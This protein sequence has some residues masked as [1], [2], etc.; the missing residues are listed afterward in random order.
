METRLKGLRQIKV[1]CIIY[2]IMFIDTTFNTIKWIRAIKTLKVIYRFCKFY[3]FYGSNPFY[4]SNILFSAFHVSST[5]FTEWTISTIH[6]VTIIIIVVLVTIFIIIILLYLLLLLL[7][8]F[9]YVVTE[10]GTAMEV[11]A[12]VPQ[13]THVDHKQVL[14]TLSAVCTH[15][16]LV[17]CVIPELLEHGRNLSVGE[18]WFQVLLLL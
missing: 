7:L 2:I 12:D 11:E 3:C 15:A 16:T 6:N 4:N 13:A 17:K 10:D 14:D 5:L 18:L 1:Y 8:L 9:Y